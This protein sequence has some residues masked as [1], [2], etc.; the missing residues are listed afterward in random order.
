[1]RNSAGATVAGRRRQPEPAAELE[2][3]G[4]EPGEVAEVDA[5][6]AEVRRALDVRVRG[7]EHTGV[8]EGLVADAALTQCGDA[9]H[10]ARVRQLVGNAGVRSEPDQRLL[11]DVLRERQRDEDLARAG[12]TDLGRGEP[13]QV[14]A[15]QRRVALGEQP[16]RLVVERRSHPEE[17]APRRRVTEGRRE[18]DVARVVDVE[19]VQRA[20][21]AAARCGRALILEEQGANHGGPGGSHEPRQLSRRYLHHGCSIQHFPRILRRGVLKI[22]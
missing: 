11:L 6:E 15:E 13:P 4:V 5:L 22:Q 7:H 18:H 14:A 17:P 2:R 12:Q 1:M 16:L 20:E 21:G 8:G 3:V 19:V 9:D 10:V